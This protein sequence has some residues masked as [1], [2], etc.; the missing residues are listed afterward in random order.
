MPA[1]SPRGGRLTFI[2]LSWLLLLGTLAGCT[3]PAPAIERPS[4]PEALIWNHPYPNLTIIVEYVEGFEPSQVALRE[5]VATLEEVTDKRAILLTEP[6]LIPNLTHD[7]GRAWSR[8]ELWE[9]YRK[10][11][12]EHGR[13][14]GDTAFLF[15]SYLDG[16]TDNGARGLRI[17]NN[18]FLFYEGVRADYAFGA[19]P[20][21]GAENNERRVL[22]HELGHALGLVNCGIPMLTPREHPDGDCHSTE[23]QSVMRAGIED[24]KVD[25][26]AATGQENTLA[27][28]RF[29]A[30]DLRDLA[31]FREK[32]RDEA[33]RAGRT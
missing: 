13:G 7:P 14:R 22:T 4:S 28:L 17:H 5:M 18:L 26:D 16:L 30:A 29:T 10:H 19:A 20:R 11:D 23:E 1:G 8:D 32:G 3:S 25:V 24:W 33:T 31:A 27:P 6:A 9:I 21:V 15:V 2:C 12:R